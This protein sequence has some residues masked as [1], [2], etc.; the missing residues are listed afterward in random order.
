MTH[1]PLDGF[2]D[3]ELLR[4]CIGE[5]A[6]DD[7]ETFL[8]I[9]TRWREP[10]RRELEDAGLDPHEAENRL[11]TVFIRALDPD[12]RIPATVPLHERLKRFAREV[13]SDPDW[14]PY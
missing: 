2:S 11:G 3:D 9:Y 14:T 4:R 12:E 7:G 6:D 10:V 5:P 8:A 1:A 13:A